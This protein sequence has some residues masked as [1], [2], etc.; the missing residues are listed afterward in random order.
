MKI[1]RISPFYNYETEAIEVE[2][3]LV[4][5]KEDSY[6]IY[7][8]LFKNDK[9]FTTGCYAAKDMDTAIK[10]AKKYHKYDYTSM[11]IKESLF[12]YTYEMLTNP[13]PAEE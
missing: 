9:Y 11:K 13:I 5:N 1:K 10:A 4:K 7:E 6:K 2:I 3:V 8:I 12:S